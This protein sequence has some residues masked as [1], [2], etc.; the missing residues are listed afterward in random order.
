MEYVFFYICMVLKTIQILLLFL[1]YM[2]FLFHDITP[3]HHHDPDPD[4]IFCI[5]H[6]HDKPGSHSDTDDSHHFPLPVHQHLSADESFDIIRTS[7]GIKIIIS[8]LVLFDY[9]SNKLLYTIY[10]PEPSGLLLYFSLSPPVNSYPFL[11]S[12][13]TLR[14]SP[15]MA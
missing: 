8:P 11:M 6:Q 2:L 9:T 1:G 15:V 13:N 12:P 3:H 14:G 7:P 4:S 5:S 10:K